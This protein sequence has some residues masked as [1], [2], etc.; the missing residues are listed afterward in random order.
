MINHLFMRDFRGIAHGEI[1]N[2]AQVNILVGPN[3]SGK[4]TILEALYLAATADVGCNLVSNEGLSIPVTVAADQDLLGQTPMA[5]IWQRHNAPARWGDAPALWD[6]ASGNIKLYGVPDALSEYEFLADRQ[7]KKGFVAEDEHLIALLR[8]QKVPDRI[9]PFP[10]F[11]K[12][13]LDADADAEAR[14]Q[15]H[16]VVLWYPPFTFKYTGLAGWFLDGQI[17]SAA[18]TLF[19]DFHTT[20]SHFTQAFIERGYR[21]IHRWPW[22]IG[23][24]FANIF[25]LP[26][27][28]VPYVSFN[29]YQP[30]PYRYEVLI[31]QYGKMVPIDM[32]GDGARHVLKLLAPLIMLSDDAERGHPGM[33]LWEDPELFLHPRAL[34]RLMQEILVIT[35]DKPIQ[36]FITT[37]SIEVVASLTTLVKD[38]AL[39]P[40]ILRAF[41]LELQQGKMIVSRFGHNNLVAWLEQGLDP[42]N[43]ERK[44]RF[45]EYHLGGAE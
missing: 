21:D 1:Q 18:H 5:R 35:K 42:R 34:H 45:L 19:Y 14:E 8:I 17:P 12:D 3:N 23:K 27:D 28:P 24:H 20:H 16:F 25:D 29:P 22:R 31:E 37:Q 41:Q 4:T 33:L 13:Y 40:E 10:A 36:I 7:A 30:D 11:V 38:M 43:L 6:S 2:F 9:P 15:R 39:A 44:D 32:W 26:T